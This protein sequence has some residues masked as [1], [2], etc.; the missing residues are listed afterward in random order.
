MSIFWTVK[1]IYEIP[2]LISIVSSDVLVLGTN[3]K[4]LFK[5][6][7]FAEFSYVYIYAKNTVYMTIVILQG[8]P[9]RMRPTGNTIKL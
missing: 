6:I 4:A 3:T 8:P 1:E 7:R 9:K 2:P 5:F